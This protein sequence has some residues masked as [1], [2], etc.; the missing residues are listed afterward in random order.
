MVYW[1]DKCGKV[2]EQKRCLT[3]FVE[4]ATT[5]RM[6]PQPPSQP[7]GRNGQSFR[8]NTALQNQAVPWAHVILFSLLKRST[9]CQLSHS[10]SLHPQLL[11]SLAGWP[12][13]FSSLLRHFL[14]PESYI[15][16]V[17]AYCFLSVHLSATLPPY[18]LQPFF[19]CPIQ[20][21]QKRGKSDWVC[22]SHPF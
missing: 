7:L 15:P 6:H 8:V 12:S 19:E 11:L 14:N 13:L 21:S 18:C 3:W 4:M 10:L 9:R 22:Q 20:T 5:F 2:E 16:I 1:E 17:S